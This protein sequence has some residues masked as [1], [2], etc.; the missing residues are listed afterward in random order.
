MRLKSAMTIELFQF[1]S[2]AGL[3][4]PQHMLYEVSGFLTTDSTITSL[5]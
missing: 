3:R 2:L 1:Y 5:S 4:R